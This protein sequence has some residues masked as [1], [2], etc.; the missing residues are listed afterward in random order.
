MSSLNSQED[1]IPVCYWSKLF[2][3]CPWH[4]L[5]KNTYGTRMNIRFE[6]YTSAHYSSHVTIYH[7]KQ[8]MWIA[9]KAQEKSRDV[10]NIW[11]SK[12]GKF[13]EEI[14]IFEMN[15]KFPLVAC[16]FVLNL[17]FWQLCSFGKTRYFITW[18]PHGYTVFLFHIKCVHVYLS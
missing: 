11:L 16:V 13:T 4:T 10:H 8:N 6:F 14:A 17:Q 18:V 5:W 9:T 3:I 15:R 2:C 1:E 12:L 7:S